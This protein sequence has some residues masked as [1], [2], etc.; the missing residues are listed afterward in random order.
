MKRCSGWVEVHPVDTHL[1][2][3]L[4]VHDVEAAAFVHQNFG[5]ALWADDR[6]DDKQIPSWKR[7]GVRMVGPIE[8]FGRLRPPEEERRVTF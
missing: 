1:V 2:E 3:R 6:V 7:D 5:E 4:C 8:G